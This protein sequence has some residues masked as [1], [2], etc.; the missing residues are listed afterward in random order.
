M[1]QTQNTSSFDKASHIF[2]RGARHFDPGL[3][4]KG[5]RSEHE[6]DV[7]E[8]VDRILQ[9]RTERLGGREVVAEAAYRVGTG[10]TS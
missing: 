9:D 6:D 5:A 1:K 10:W 7:D 2:G 3:G 8:G 4:E